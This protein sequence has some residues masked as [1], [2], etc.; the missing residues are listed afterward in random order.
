MTSDHPDQN[1]NIDNKL[2]LIGG[3]T[4]LVLTLSALLN[5][6]NRNTFISLLIFL[7]IPIYFIYNGF[8]KTIRQ[9]E[10]TFSKHLSKNSFFDTFSFKEFLM[11]SEPIF[12]IT[13]ILISLSITIL[14]YQ[15]GLLFTK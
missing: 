15:T 12:L 6:D 1:L 10:L 3:L 2:F 7:P 8:K 9:I 14:M 4:T 5:I 11:Q 13:A